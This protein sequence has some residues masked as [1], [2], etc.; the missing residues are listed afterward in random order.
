RGQAYDRTRGGEGP[1]IKSLSPQN[2][3]RQIASDAATWL[4]RKLTAREPLVIAD[5]GFGRDVRDALHRRAE[6]LVKMGH[7]TL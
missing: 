7:A 4:D 6:H 1:R 5:G 3:E 2:L